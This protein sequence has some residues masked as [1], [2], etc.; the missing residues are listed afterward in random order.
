MIAEPKK[1]LETTVR[2]NQTFA[3]PREK[4][5]RAW[6]NPEELKKWWGP[7]GCSTPSAEIE[8]RVGGKYRFGMQFP[9]EDIFYVS[10]TYREV[11]PPTKLVFTWRWEK[12]ETDIGESLVTV[13]FYDRGGVTEVVLTHEQFPNKEA[14]QQHLQGWSSIFD[15][16]A[17]VIIAG[18]E[19]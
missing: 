10:G 4:V 14:Y 8:L 6:T 15:K 5:F 2:L 11:Q 7:A 16:L 9:Q 17:E 18:K 12:P 1:N 13:E 19:A 3:A